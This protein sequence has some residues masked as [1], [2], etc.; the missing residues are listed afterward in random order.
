MSQT[1]GKHRPTGAANPTDLLLLSPLLLLLLR[2]LLLLPGEAR[3]AILTSVQREQ[4]V[5]RLQLLL[6]PS[7]PSASK[8]TPP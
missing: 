8:F 2:L 4:V 5:V 7:I 6:L 3:D 1:E